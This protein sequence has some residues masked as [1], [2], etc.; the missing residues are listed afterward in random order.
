MKPTFNMIRNTGERLAA[1]RTR[2]Q[3]V[4]DTIQ[5]SALIIETAATRSN[6]QMLRKLATRVY[7]AA[8]L[9]VTAIIFREEIKNNLFSWIPWI[10]IAD[11]GD[12]FFKI[13]GFFG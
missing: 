13:F 11:I 2:L 3:V 12:L 10:S 4:T 6:T 8:G 7:W 9:G 5:T 1:L